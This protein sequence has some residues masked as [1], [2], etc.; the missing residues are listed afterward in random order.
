MFMRISDYFKRGTPAAVLTSGKLGTTFA[1]TAYGI[2]RHSKVLEPV[3]VVDEFESGKK[4]SDFVTHVKYDVPIVSSV[5]EARELGAEVLILGIATIGGVFTQEVY[6]HIKRALELGMSVVNGLHQKL[7]DIPEFVRISSE[8]GAE[9]VDV[10]VP[11]KD[12][13][14]LSGEIFSLKSAVVGVFGTD[15]AVGKRTTAVQL[16]NRALERGMKAGFLATG[17]TGIMIGADEGIAVDA[18]PGDFI[19]GVLERVVM[20]LSNRFD[21]IFV[22]GQASILHPSYGQVALGILYGTRPSRVVLVHD[23]DYPFFSEFDYQIPTDLNKEIEA[24]EFLGGARVVA[25]ASLSKNRPPG[26]IDPF[27][28]DDLDRVLDT[29]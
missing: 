28:V 7:T 12:L 4:V 14:I 8:T 13:R 29:L 10:R 20:S 25:I 3:C 23:F 18:V 6:P 5:D 19:P 2:L 26:V 1:K 22:E 15:C 11:P 16:W 21:L 27:D 24:L 17:Q 9:L